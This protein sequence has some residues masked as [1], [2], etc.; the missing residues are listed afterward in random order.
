MIIS[1]I[2]GFSICNITYVLIQV[3]SPLTYNVSATAKASF[4]TLLGVLYYEETKTIL[5]WISNILVLFGAT[6]Y[7]YVRNKEMNM[8]N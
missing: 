3:T 5:W 1:G 6:L 4:Q 2:L 8:K 7:S